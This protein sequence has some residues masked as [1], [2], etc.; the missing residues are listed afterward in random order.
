M[1]NYRI[2]TALLTVIVLGGVT[3]EGRADQAGGTGQW[4]AGPPPPTQ[5]SAN[6]LDI[7]KEGL[8]AI[9]VGIVASQDCKADFVCNDFGTD[10]RTDYK[11]NCVCSEVGIDAESGDKEMSLC[12]GA[13]HGTSPPPPPPTEANRQLK[14]TPPIRAMLLQT[15]RPRS[16]VRLRV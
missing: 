5:A 6:P 10:A 3:W 7:T 13:W 4:A 8:N 2:V 16:A 11:A 15:C 12:K 14:V 9:S 1:K